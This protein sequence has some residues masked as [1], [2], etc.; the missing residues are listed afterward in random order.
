M[1][2]NREGLQEKEISKYNGILI[3]SMIMRLK[4]EDRILQW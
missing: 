4:R 3:S 2:I 1:S